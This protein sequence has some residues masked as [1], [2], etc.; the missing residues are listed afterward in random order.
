MTD[1]TAA[2]TAVPA[3]GT[4][5]RYKRLALVA[6]LFAVSMTFIDQTI[7]AIA[8]PSI[9]S[10]LDLTRTGTQ[11]A[12]NAYLLA[13][14]ATFALGGRL[15]DVMGP[16]RMVVIGIIGFAG[17]SALCGA[18]P[19]GSAAQAWLTTFRALQGVSGALM[20]PAALAIVVAAFPIAERGRAMALF[21]G[22]SGGLTAV[23][24]IAGGFLTQWTWRS[25]F[26]I[27][28]PIALALPRA[29]RRGRHP[30]PPH[31]ERHDRPRRRVPDRGRHGPVCPR[32]RAG[33]RRGAGTARR[34]GCSSS[35]DSA[36]SSSSPWSSY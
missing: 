19:T 30:E 29:R 15:A 35:A 17:S 36:S 10:E 8:S 32:L 9:Q 13:L 28:V 1:I 24:P 20:V 34:P 5:S 22:I 12:V 6:M 27:N 14:A 16:R 2:V 31:R 18:T 23:G 7:V 21:F 3:A 26:W 25:I 4:T 11:W 33:I